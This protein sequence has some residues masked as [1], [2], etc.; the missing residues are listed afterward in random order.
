MRAVICMLLRLNGMGFCV[1]LHGMLICCVS[2]SSMH[3]QHSCLLR[4][5]SDQP[6]PPPHISAIHTAPHPRSLCTGGVRA[7]G[8]ASS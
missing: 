6:F 1:R 3:E 7:A 2:A 8:A 4:C 5:V